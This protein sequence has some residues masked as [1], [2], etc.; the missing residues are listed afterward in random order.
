MKAY[1]KCTECNEDYR[2]HN[3][4]RSYPETFEKAKD[5]PMCV[6]CGQDTLEW[7]T[8]PSSDINTFK[9][10]FDFYH[11]VFRHLDGT[12]V[13]DTEGK[14]VEADHICPRCY[15]PATLTTVDCYYEYHTCNR[16]THTFTVS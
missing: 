1:F 8:E 10:H 7:L 6:S 15:G 9:T 11:Q 12:I 3:P 4:Y 2:N 13:R 14:H 5:K 16:C